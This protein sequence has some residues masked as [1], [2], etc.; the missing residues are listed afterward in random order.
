MEYIES[1]IA[2]DQNKKRVISVTVRKVLVDE[3]HAYC[4]NTSRA[5]EAGIEA[6]V[7]QAKEQAWLVDNAVAIRAH[8]K[9]V[10][11]EG[12]LITPPWLEE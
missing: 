8:Q 3:A 2:A 10:S 12:M 1:N 6:A 11:T 9:R 4:L 7:R 5:A